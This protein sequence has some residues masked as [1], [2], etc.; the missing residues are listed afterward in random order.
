MKEYIE[1][2]VALNSLE[3]I[4]NIVCEQG[5]P[6]IGKAIRTGTYLGIVFCRNEVLHAPAA[7]VRP[8]IHS[9]WEE[10]SGD[11]LY[12]TDATKDYKCSN[13]KSEFV[14]GG[15]YCPECGATMRKEE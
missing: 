3:E 6:R 12:G 14:E 10:G 1:R 9:T 7:D 11:W 2:E 15:K 4:M 13:C 5:N 8:V